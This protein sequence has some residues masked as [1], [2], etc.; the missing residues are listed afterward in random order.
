MVDDTFRTI[1]KYEFNERSVGL[2]NSRDCSEVN[3]WCD[4]CFTESAGGGV[5]VHGQSRREKRYVQ[6][7]MSADFLRPFMDGTNIIVVH[8][9]L[10]QLFLVDYDS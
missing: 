4:F 6:D 5:R 8:L 2:I 9:P 1:V 3:G 7:L 10:P